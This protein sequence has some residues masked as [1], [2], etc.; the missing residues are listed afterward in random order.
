MEMCIPARRLQAW[1]VGSLAGHEV[2]QQ[3]SVGTLARHQEIR[4]PHQQVLLLA[5]LQKS[6]LSTPAERG[7]DNTSNTTDTVQHLANAV[8]E[9]YLSGAGR[10]LVKEV[11]LLR[12]SILTPS[13]FNIAVHIEQEHAR[14]PIPRV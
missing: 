13:A 7:S 12:P 6:T 8:I 4:H 9:L 11:H 3:E 2:Q 14:R 5:P 10:L 1:H